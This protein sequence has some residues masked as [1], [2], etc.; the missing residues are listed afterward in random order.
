MYA[1]QMADAGV[2]AIIGAH[3]HRLQGCSFIKDVPV[4]YSIGNFWFST[5]SLYTSIAQI[6][7]DK[8]GKLTMR[9]LPCIQRK[10]KTSI[11]TDS[12]KKDIF[13]RYLADV[14]R[15]VG[16]DKNG[17]LY[18]LDFNQNDTNKADS[19]GTKRKNSTEHI[20]SDMEYKSEKGYS[21]HNSEY[22]IDGNRIDRV[23]NL[24]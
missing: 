10:L 1:E 13:Y 15:K 21:K 20:K 5:G 17:T 23:G 18:N 4:A 11:I 9:M 8:K 2:D 6:R 14:S 16:I 24:E 12:K 19:K 7:I 3:P 22:D